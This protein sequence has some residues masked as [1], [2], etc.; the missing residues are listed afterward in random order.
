M[1]YEALLVGLRLARSLN[2]KKLQAFS[3][4]QLVVK[5]NLGEYEAREEKMAQYLAEVKKL[6]KRFENF[7]IQVIIREQN[8]V[9]DALSMLASAEGDHLDGLV[10]LEYL[11][12]LNIAKPDVMEITI[13]HSWL[14]P[15]V[16]FLERGILPEDPKE[17]RRI[18]FKSSKFCM[19][20]GI[21]YK[22]AFLA[23]MFKYID[24]TE[25]NYYLEEVHSGICGEHMGGKALAHKIFRQGYFWLTIY[26]DAKNYVQ[27]CHQCQI[28]ANVPRKPA[29]S[30]VA[31][32]SS[33]TEIKEGLS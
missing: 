3:D 32:Y 20:K 8:Q 6:I 5:Q 24:K 33:L 29:E 12:M 7:A 14:T 4:S 13:E 15:I 9:V 26:G 27:K 31:R 28:H 25:A 21:L 18:K 17:S 30:R 2:V 11:D 23:P 16:D 10:Y 22:R 1:K 19:S